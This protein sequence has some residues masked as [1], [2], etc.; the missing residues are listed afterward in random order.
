[1]WSNIGS[2]LKDNFFQKTSNPFLGTLIM[3]WSIKNWK[4]VYSLFY[5]DNDCDLN[6][7][8]ELISEYFQH[9]TFLDFSLTVIVSFLVLIITYFLINLS[10]LIINFYEKKVTPVVYRITDKNSVVLRSELLKEHNKYNDLEKRYQEERDKR[11][12][13]QSEIDD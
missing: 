8:I 4:F 9:Y 10:R 11:L 7:R 13:A 6:C 1:M 2:S 5:F 12:K 3:V